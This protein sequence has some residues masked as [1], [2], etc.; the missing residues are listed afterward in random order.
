MFFFPV[1]SSGTFVVRRMCVRV[2]VCVSKTSH[3]LIENRKEEKATALSCK[4]CRYLYILVV[5]YFPAFL[6]FV[7]N[8]LNALFGLLSTPLPSFYI[9]QLF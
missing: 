3:L 5:K 6:M 1:P 7:S 8:F 4:Y 2:N 9:L